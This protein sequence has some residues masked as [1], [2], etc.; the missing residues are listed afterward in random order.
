VIRC[1]PITACAFCPYRK[2]NYGRWEC[3]QMNHQELP[4]QAVENGIATPPPVWCPL[5]PHPSFAVAPATPEVA[6]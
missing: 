1:I 2:R 4:P 5:P 6:Q 3:A